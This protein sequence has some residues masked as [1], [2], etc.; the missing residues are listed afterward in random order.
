MEERALSE[1]LADWVEAEIISTDQAAAI[2][3]HEAQRVPSGDSRLPRWVEPLAYLGVALVGVA[4]LLFVLEVWD[5]LE[6]WGQVALAA[7]V[8]V[9]L[10]VAGAALHRSDASAARRAGAVARAWALVGVAGTVALAGDDLLGFDAEVA[11]LV[12]AV[13]TVV[14]ALSLYLLART[15][16][17]Q[18]GLTAAAVFLLAAVLSLLPLASSATAALLFTSLGVVWLLLTW[19]GLLTPREAG[20]ASG[21]LLTLAVGFGGADPEQPAW[22]AAA[23]AAALALVYLATLLDS[24][25]VLAVALLGLV[26]WIP[27]TVT[28]VF[29][30]S[31]AVPAAILVTG[32]VTLAVTVLGVRRVTPSSDAPVGDDEVTSQVGSDA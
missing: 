22:S 31:V 9:V 32:V 20:W 5:D 12:S 30:G 1:R 23:V 28:Q 15:V 13:T 4:L 18:V 27:V 8:T 19:G 14:A 2:E 24:R 21:G 17:Q 10:L 7:I 3:N 6:D 11:A 29:E 25:W 16:L 26:V